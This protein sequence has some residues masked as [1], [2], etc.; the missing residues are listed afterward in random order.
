MHVDVPQLA[1]MILAVGFMLAQA[2]IQPTKARA[3]NQ[4]HVNAD[5]WRKISPGLW[6]SDLGGYQYPEVEEGL[7]RATKAILDKAWEDAN[8]LSQR[9]SL[10]MEYGL[11]NGVSALRSLS[12]DEARLLEPSHYGLQLHDGKSEAEA[13][14]YRAV[15][16]LLLLGGNLGAAHEV[17][18]GVTPTELEEAEHA[19][20]HPGQ[21]PWAEEHPW[22][23]SDTSDLLH[24]AIHRLEG[25]HRGEGNHTGYENA[26]YWALGGPKS[27]TKPARHPVRE[28]L[29]EQALKVAPLLCVSGG[30][31]FGA[32]PAE[33][34]DDDGSEQQRVV[35]D[36]LAFID[37]C[38]LRHEGELSEGKCAEVVHLQILELSALLH[39]E[40]SRVW[41]RPARN[42]KTNE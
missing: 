3:Q 4:H 29:A 12:R 38:R 18:L 7:P 9:T 37:L 6:G 41:K 39:S 27:L 20:T 8:T 23:F 14:F 16:I 2:A 32:S 36:D 26:R 15:A 13:S 1:S 30:L 31:L 17:L 5:Y 10:L 22:C 24:A 33:S 21:T 34:D 11:F 40:L 42:P 35:W 28:F 19:A 25:A